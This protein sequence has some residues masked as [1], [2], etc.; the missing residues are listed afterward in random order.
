MRIIQLAGEGSPPP[1]LRLSQAELSRKSNQLARARI[2]QFE[3][4]MP[5][6]AVG[7]TGASQV[8]ACTLAAGGTPARRSESLRA[9]VTGSP[10]KKEGDDTLVRSPWLLAI[11]QGLQSEYAACR[12]RPGGNA[13]RFRLLNHWN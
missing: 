9:A 4:Y 11:G 6:H 1:G 7:L 8:A 3:S 10:S 12:S 2:R 13:P 5:R